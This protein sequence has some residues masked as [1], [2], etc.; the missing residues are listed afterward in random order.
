MNTVD[1][2]AS[3]KASS[4]ASAP[5]TP[6]G[7]PAPYGR[8][9]ANCVK[10]KCKCFYRGNGREI[11]SCERC[12]RLGKD[13]VPSETVRRR[14][15]RRQ[16]T[17]RTAQLEEKLDDLV[18]LLKTHQQKPGVGPA[19]TSI[20][21]SRGPLS[22]N[23]EFSLAGPALL[24]STPIITM[25]NNQQSSTMS[26]LYP[27]GRKH[28]I[29]A[30]H[31]RLR[32]PSTSASSTSAP[33]FSMQPDQ[34]AEESLQVFSKQ[35]LFSFP[36]FRVTEDMTA[37][38]LQAQYPLFMLAIK[39]ISCKVFSRQMKYSEELQHM[40]AQ[41][42][43]MDY[44]NSMDLL[45]A[46]I[47]CIA[48]IHFHEARRPFLT[49]MTRLAISQVV[50]LGLH[51]PF[52]EPSGI[53]SFRVASG[54]TFAN[55]EPAHIK[56][57]NEHRRAALGCFVVTSWIYT[58][59]RRAEGLPWTS[60]LEGM[61]VHLLKESDWDGDKILVA[62]VKVQRLQ[63]QLYRARFHPAAGDLG[64]AKDPHKGLPSYYINL[65]RQTSRDLRYS[66]PDDIAGDAASVAFLLRYLEL[67]IAESALDYKEAPFANPKHV[68]LPTSTRQL[69]NIHAL[70][71]AFE[72]FF[73]LVL[74][75]API[76]FY[77]MPYTFSGAVPQA[78]W[79]LLKL[80][81]SHPDSVWDP[82]EISQ[83]INPTSI[84]DAMRDKLMAIPESAGLTNVSTPDTANP[85]APQSDNIFTKCGPILDSVRLRWAA[86]LQKHAAPPPP[87]PPSQEGT[88]S[89]T[90]NGSAIPIT[91]QGPIATQM[92]MQTG[93]ESH[94]QHPD[95][96]PMLMPQYDYSSWLSFTPLEQGWYPMDMS[97]S[98]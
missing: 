34:E 44:D 11:S 36:Y 49:A 5:S 50:E 92:N 26:P 7:I 57:S 93:F 1:S 71:E 87:L 66:L 3:S 9:C 61:M 20:T 69:E 70:V 22:A 52:G 86:E 74:D 47:T 16:G 33:S 77:G 6:P 39:S 48:W 30:P 98:Q 29:D 25:P 75:L 68:N 2:G 19:A 80:C 83:R 21:T 78:M 27:K 45:L 88:P 38:K 65:L 17:S 60:Y 91:Q 28:S 51:R 76:H 73:S 55:K 94:G 90:F 23:K 58:S 18:S 37:S 41:K 63:E 40:L 24:D 89:A 59:M 31:E 81:L 43:L 84:V 4:T 67:A 54:D 85:D 95:M 15:S 53:Y 12:H 97:Y 64:L 14:T 56:P 35:F 46:L 62:N 10:A 96:M 32:A 79:M 82:R 72:R 8:A 42:L 13:C